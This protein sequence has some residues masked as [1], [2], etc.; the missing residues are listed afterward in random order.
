MDGV[1]GSDNVDFITNMSAFSFR[2]GQASRESPVG[3]VELDVLR[4]L[5]LPAV[6]VRE[7]AFPVVIGRELE[8]RHLLFQHPESLV[9]IVVMDEY[10]AQ[11]KA[12]LGRPARLGR[13]YLLLA[14][15]LHAPE[16][17]TNKFDGL[18]N[19]RSGELVRRMLIRPE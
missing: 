4:D 19:F 9:D 16:L 18:F 3:R 5:P 15:W 8:V 6:A 2:Q 11:E 7:Q 1:F 13:L 17:K 10:P 12:A 14:T